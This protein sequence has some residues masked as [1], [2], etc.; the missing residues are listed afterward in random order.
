MCFVC[1]WLMKGRGSKVQVWWVHSES[2]DGKEAY[3]ASLAQLRARYDAVHAAH[4]ALLRPLLFHAASALPWLP[5][6]LQSRSAAPTAFHGIVYHL[7][8][9]NTGVLKQVQPVGLSDNG[10]LVNVFFVIAWL[11]GPAL[12]R[13]PPTLTESSD[14]EGSEGDEAVAALGACVRGAR[15]D[16]TPPGRSR[17]RARGHA[18]ESKSPQTAEAQL[19]RGGSVG[20]AAAAAAR[21]TDGAAPA[22]TVRAAASTTPPRSPT[23]PQYGSPRGFGRGGRPAMRGAGSQHSSIWRFPVSLFVPSK[24]P[25]EAAADHYLGLNR[26]G[27]L[28]SEAMKA[29]PAV[30]ELEAVDL[31]SIAADVVA[32]GAPARPRLHQ[33]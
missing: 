29:T 9:R 8:H 11:L 3:Q 27:G 32:T 25:V 22:R 14:S 6:A 19:P 18:R 21:S 4:V 30:E 16:R 1:E 15:A 28:V 5:P 13:L 7:I 2:S 17:V 10:V 31:R 20:A 24:V 12:S 23:A 26:V 33:A